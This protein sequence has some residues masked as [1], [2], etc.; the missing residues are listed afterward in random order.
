M[1]KYNWITILLFTILSAC[2][3]HTE[4]A[5]TATTPAKDSNGY[6]PVAAALSETDRETFRTDSILTAQLEHKVA[7]DTLLRT[8]TRQEKV[9]VLTELQECW[10]DSCQ[11][12]SYSDGNYLFTLQQQH[13]DSTRN[14]S[15]QTALLQDGQHTINFADYKVTCY[16]KEHCEDYGFN[17]KN[18]LNNARVIEVCG[19]RFLYANMSYNCNGMGCGCVMTM[20]YDM[21]T[22][23]PTFIENYR[24]PY[25]GYFISDFN[26]DN[27]PDLLVIEKSH[28]RKLKKYATSGFDLTLHAYTY[29]NGRFVPTQKKSTKKPYQY[30]LYGIGPDGDGLHKTYSVKQN[31]WY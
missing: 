6:K 31:N 29:H 14:P 21:Q 5:T 30:V 11:Y 18:S 24:I 23:H 2:Q 3:Q 16:N 27:N 25:D 26:N 7:L 9:K 19:K 12:Y 4:K 28:T 22:K 15:G 20:V 13:C 1:K 8:I 17:Q 10:V